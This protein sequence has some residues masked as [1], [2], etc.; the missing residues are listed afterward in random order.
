MLIQAH[1]LA[2]RL[3]EPVPSVRVAD[4]RWYLNQPGRGRRE[5]ETGHIPGAIFVDLDADLA[6]PEGL[7]APGRHP[8]PDPTAFA[9]RLGEL[10]IGDQHL[11]VAY[12][13]AGGSI[14]AR[15]W[16][17]LDNLGHPNAAI[18]DGGIQAWI[19]AGNALTAA[20]NARPPAELHVRS[21]W[22]R[23]IDRETLAGQLGSVSLLDARA[24]DRYRPHSD[25]PEPAN[26]WQ[27]RAKRPISACGGAR[28][29]LPR[30]RHRPGHQRR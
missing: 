2:A 26:R 10:G 14:A 24:G 16:W 15:L 18:L 3:A 11:V 27:P 4:V 5:H 20:E 22:R 7:G 8:L 19:E 1:E 9:R 12:D 30:H 6:D 23:A 17:M 21:T 29:T 25:R 13:D 28:G